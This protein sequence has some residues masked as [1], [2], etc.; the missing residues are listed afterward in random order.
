M[1]VLDEEDRGGAKV[2]AV[3]IANLWRDNGLELT[4]VVGA[5]DGEGAGEL[6]DEFSRLGRIAEHS[7]ADR[8]LEIP[9]D[10]VADGDGGVGFV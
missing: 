10:V 1:I 3:K 7:G 4:F 5:E 8:R 9:I 2:G 6:A